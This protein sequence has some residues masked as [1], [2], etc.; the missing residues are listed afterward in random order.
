VL[1]IY[2]RGVQASE[3][4]DEY[5]SH[6]LVVVRYSLSLSLS[7][8]FR[9]SV[10]EYLSMA[11]EKSQEHYGDMMH[12]LMSCWKKSRMKSRGNIWDSRL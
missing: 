3:N 5:P 10:C 7:L 11:I 6:A 9:T 2:L 8:C 4:C 12:F 1:A